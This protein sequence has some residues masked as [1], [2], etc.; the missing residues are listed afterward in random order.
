MFT[1]DLERFLYND[2]QNRF[3]FFKMFKLNYTR[4]AKA[5][6]YG[7]EYL[8]PKYEESL[9]F[10]ISDRAIFKKKVSYDIL[11]STSA[12]SKVGHFKKAFGNFFVS[13]CE[14]VSTRA[15]YAIRFKKL[16]Y[17]KFAKAYV[18]NLYW[19]RLYP[20]IC[21]VKKTINTRF[22]GSNTKLTFTELLT[23]QQFRRHPSSQIRSIGK[24][25]SVGT[26]MD[27]FFTYDINDVEVIDHSRFYKVY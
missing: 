4:R 7:Y 26:N 18:K 15:A 17:S 5:L 14:S 25:L 11:M 20:S 23:Y 24:V 10:L 13:N 27:S 2:Y 9:P 12:K 3:S 16:S 22:L 1:K 6:F 8:A 21:L 19:G